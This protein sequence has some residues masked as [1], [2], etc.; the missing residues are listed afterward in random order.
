MDFPSA[1]FG[2][3]G[4][5]IET[6]LYFS[7]LAGK[8]DY[9]TGSMVTASATTHSGVRSV[10]AIRADLAVSFV[11]VCSLRLPRRTLN[12]VLGLWSLPAKFRFPETEISARRDAVRMRGY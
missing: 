6:S 10:S 1:I 7:L 8:L 11:R 4:T 3:A 9:K 5:V 12:T 2:L